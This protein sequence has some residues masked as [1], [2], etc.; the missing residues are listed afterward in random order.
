MGRAKDSKGRGALML[1]GS[2]ATPRVGGRDKGPKKK[3]RGGKKRKKRAQRAQD[4][5]SKKLKKREKEKGETRPSASSKNAMINESEHFP[6]IKSTFV[7]DFVCPKVMK[8]LPFFLVVLLP[9]LVVATTN[10]F[11]SPFGSDQSGDGSSGNPYQT[12][13]KAVDEATTGDT[14]MLLPGSYGGRKTR[15]KKYLFYNSLTT[16]YKQALSLYPKI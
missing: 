14:V 11:V 5:E 2:G 16:K 8:T 9:V 10:I 6:H 4:A 7:P 1:K 12:I 3:K 15:K 13:Q